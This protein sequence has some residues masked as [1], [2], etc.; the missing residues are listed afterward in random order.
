MFLWACMKHVTVVSWNWISVLFCHILFYLFFLSLV[1]FVS[2]I[3]S[4]VWDR[5]YVTSNT[6][7]A[8]QVLRSKSVE[9]G[10]RDLIPCGVFLFNVFLGR[11]LRGFAHIFRQMSVS[12]F[13]VGLLSWRSE[14]EWSEARRRRRLLDISQTAHILHELQSN[15]S[16]FYSV[17]I[18]MITSPVTRR[19]LVPLL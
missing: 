18:Y 19:C 1:A 8:F 9:F 3:T 10:F 12:C 17:W 13:R 2:W 14:V 16:S 5:K 15:L 6:N 11:A 7:P 4:G